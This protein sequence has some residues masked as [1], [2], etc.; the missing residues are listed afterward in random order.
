MKMMGRKGVAVLV[1]ALVAAHAVA[2]WWVGRVVE[3]RYAAVRGRLLLAL[4]IA[5]ESLVAHR[6]ERGVFS[7]TV[8]DVLVLDLPPLSGH[9]MPHARAA[10]AFVPAGAAGDASRARPVRVH[11]RQ[12]IRHG[13]LPGLHWGAAAIEVRI[14]R[15]EGLD[16]GWRKALE[17]ASPP[18]LVSVIGFDGSERGEFRW[19]DGEF[20]LPGPAGL[21]LSWK[22]LV[23]DYRVDAQRRQGQGSWRWPQFRMRVNPAD[24]RQPALH[25]ELVGWQFDHETG[26]TGE[27]WLMPP[28]SAHGRIERLSVRTAGP[29]AAPE[30][31]FLTWE[32][33]ETR[34]TIRQEGQRLQMQ[35][36]TQGRG[37]LA[38]IA[39]D[40]MRSEHRIGGIDGL[41]LRDLQRALLKGLVEAGRQPARGA[42][43][44]AAPEPGNGLPALF[45]RLLAMKPVYQ[46]RLDVRRDD[47]A[48]SLQA[49]V[50]VL[51]GTPLSPDLALDAQLAARTGTDIA[52]RLPRAWAPALARATR[53]PE[54][55]GQTLTD[56][57]DRLVR[58]GMLGR[59]GEDWLVDARI[60]GRQV[61]FQEWPASPAVAEPRP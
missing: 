35:S 57:A 3:A 2:S 18:T 7:A 42:G 22:T 59:D 28:G 46:K 40:E 48:G 30:T 44:L 16:T 45:D 10:G 50:R 6:Y 19:P 5:P 55:D 26:L 43:W 32:K 60:R 4:G 37:M 38:G 23:Y 25:V 47:R 36:S 8:T 9:G 12:H 20:T 29:G 24:R 56:M 34:T 17:R 52:A 53:R 27:Q 33:A 41:V 51:D 58:R 14:E 15:V 39:F 11:L 21:Q 31:R 49:E 61:Q 54:L 13:P 1:M